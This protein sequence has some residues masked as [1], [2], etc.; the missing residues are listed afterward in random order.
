M[1]GG[2]KTWTGK[3]AVE[4]ELPVSKIVHLETSYLKTFE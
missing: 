4:A 3:R 2:F 1:V